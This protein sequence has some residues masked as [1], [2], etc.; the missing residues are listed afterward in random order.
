M[1]GASNVRVQAGAGRAYVAGRSVNIDASQGALTLG[2][3]SNIII[4][5]GA[6]N[7]G[8]YINKWN[9]DIVVF[10][11]M[12]VL[13]TNGDGTQN[14]MSFAD[15]TSKCGFSVGRYN[16][17]LFAGT[18][19]YAAYGQVI[20]SYTSVDSIGIKCGFSVGNQAVRVN[21]VIICWP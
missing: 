9:C 19:D 16:C 7:S 17:A 13:R 4:D 18:S 6:I 8:I 10:H 21:W 14:V 20:G 1:Q 11:G 5:S 15:L 3:S 2:S 12:S